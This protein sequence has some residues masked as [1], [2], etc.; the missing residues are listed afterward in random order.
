MFCSFL[1]FALFQIPLLSITFNV[2]LTLCNFCILQR[3]L[4]VASLVLS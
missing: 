4:S 3:F 2:C 1:D